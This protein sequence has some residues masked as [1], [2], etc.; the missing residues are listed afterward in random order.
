MYATATPMLL[1]LNHSHD[2]CID[3]WRLEKETLPFVHIS[4]NLHSKDV[5][6]NFETL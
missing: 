6:L 2:S 4:N 3:G 1:S 5:D